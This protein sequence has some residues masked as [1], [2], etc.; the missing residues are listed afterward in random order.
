[1]AL[2]KCVECGRDISDT[3]DKC[4]HCGCPIEKKKVRK[5]RKIILAAV[6][7]CV[8]FAVIIGIFVINQGGVSLFPH[9][10]K[11]TQLMKLMEYSNSA[12]IKEELGDDYEHR[13]WDS[14]DST[15]DEYEDIA[16]DGKIYTQ[17]E[18]SYESNGDFERIY[19]DSGSVWTEEEYKVL[20]KDFIEQYGNEYDYEEDEYNGNDIYD[21]SW[22]MS[23]NRKISLSI[24]QSKDDKNLYWVRIN[25]FHN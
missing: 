21:Y 24:H 17:V 9:T 6:G 3:S 1:M 10:I 5:K 12:D 15:S 13:V 19:L 25:S 14:L 2:I 7:I 8:L 23:L 22:K 16:I 11:N 20:I 4:I 18:L